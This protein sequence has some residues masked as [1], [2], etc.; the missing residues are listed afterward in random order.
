MVA[1]NSDVVAVAQIPAVAEL[2][3]IA[4]QNCHN[5]TVKIWITVEQANFQTRNRIL[6]WKKIGWYDYGKFHKAQE[7]EL[8]YIRENM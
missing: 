7:N 8:Q 5:D 3:P 6:L 1:A 2:L 4:D